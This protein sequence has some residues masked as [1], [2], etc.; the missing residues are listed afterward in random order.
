MTIK[1][2]TVSEFTPHPGRE[3]A[4]KQIK[5]L[6]EEKRILEQKLFAI[7]APS[8]K[9]IIKADKKETYICALTS[10][11]HIGS[12]YRNEDALVAFYKYAKSLGVKDFLCAGDVLDGHGI[13]KGHTFELREVGFDRQM[14]ALIDITNRLPKNITTHFITGNHDAAFTKRVGM[15]VGPQIERECR[16]M[17]FIGP[18]FGNITIDRP[19][20][21]IRIALLHP[22]GG[23]AYALSY[24]TQKIIESWEG[25]KKPHILGVGH[26]HKAEYMPRYRNVKGIQAGC[27]QEQTPFMMRK[28]LAAHVGGW[29]IEVTLGSLYN[30]I[31]TEFVEFF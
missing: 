30:R 17:K 31:Q 8:Q 2:K 15:L 19:K 7:T 1:K 10:D 23:T 5:K 21:S 14:N 22:D 4:D 25:G 27:F 20:S 29:I 13:Y 3:N 12:L 11:W 9:Y 16:N 24:K 26:F 18:D 28:G 6:E